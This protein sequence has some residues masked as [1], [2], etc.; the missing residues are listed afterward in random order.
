M[1]NGRSSS[2]STHQVVAGFRIHA[3]LT[4]VKYQNSD[5]IGLRGGAWIGGSRKNLEKVKCLVWT[6]CKALK[7]LKTAK[8]LFGDPWHWNHTSLE[9]FGIGT[10]IYLEALL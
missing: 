8:T 4:V 2:G 6:Y 5:S 3:R 10:A 1:A 7:F 9:K